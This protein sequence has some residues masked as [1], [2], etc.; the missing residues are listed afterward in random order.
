MNCWRFADRLTSR[1]N[2]HFTRWL[3]GPNAEP[4]DI[5][6]TEYLS[7]DDLS[8]IAPKMPYGKNGW[9]VSKPNFAN[10]DPE[11]FKHVAEF[12]SSGDFN[13]PLRDEEG[14]ELDEEGIKT[15]TLEVC[16]KAWG[17]AEQIPLHSL[18][19]L[20]VEKVWDVQPFPLL[21]ILLFANA[22][23]DNAE[24]PFFEADTALR[25]ILS[26]FIGQRFW[27]YVEYLGEEFMK[28]LQERPE[29]RQHVFHRMSKQARKEFDEEMSV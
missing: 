16:L 9:I 27:D 1:L 26:A 13:V 6:M 3:I 2:R 24:Q 28:I 19:E 17:V 10:I 7:R 23:Y 18:M 25:K 14:N 4:F 29:L 8:K 22:I 20:I 5:P 12:L 15:A 11:H 21:A